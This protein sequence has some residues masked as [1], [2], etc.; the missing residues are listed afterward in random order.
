V[1][2]K[3][4]LDE[5]RTGDCTI[6]FSL[7]FGSKIGSMVGP[8]HLDGAFTQILHTV[9][10]SACRFPCGLLCPFLPSQPRS[11]SHPWSGWDRRSVPSTMAVGGMGGG[12]GGDGIW[13]S[14][15]SPS[16]GNSNGGVSNLP[17]SHW[18]MKACVGIGSNGNRT[19]RLFGWCWW[20]P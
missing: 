9:E 12:E 16:P 19:R 11:R 6:I 15:T 1:R 3:S 18:F 4:F 17:L 13:V 7:P 14:R 10:G 2:G 8:V 20:V 5:F